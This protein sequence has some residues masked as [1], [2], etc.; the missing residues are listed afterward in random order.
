MFKLFVKSKNFN[1]NINAFK[2][3]AIGISFINETNYGTTNYM[4]Y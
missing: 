2:K 4:F 1:D 3:L